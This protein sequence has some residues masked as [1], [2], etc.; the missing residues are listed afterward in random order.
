MRID[1]SNKIRDLAQEKDNYRQIAAAAGDNC[2]F[3]VVLQQKH[4]NFY[5]SYRFK[6][7]GAHWPLKKTSDWNCACGVVGKMDKI[8]DIA[9]LGV[10]DGE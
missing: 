8:L 1:A 5:V 7:P 3:P 6:M 10:V 9:M 4:I 2:F